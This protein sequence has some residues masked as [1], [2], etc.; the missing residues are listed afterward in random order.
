MQPAIVLGATHATVKHSSFNG[1]R[2]VIVQPIGCDEAADGPP[3]V[4]VDALGA[5]KGDHVILTSDGTYAREVTEH[6][7]TPARWSVAGIIDHDNQ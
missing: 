1:R 5:R 6:K 4:V 2:L 3:L 7:Q